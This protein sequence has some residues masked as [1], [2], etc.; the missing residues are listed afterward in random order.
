MATAIF[1]LVLVQQCLWNQATAKDLN[2]YLQFN[3]EICT[4]FLIF[5]C[6]YFINPSFDQ[7]YLG[8][9]TIWRSKLRKHFEECEKHS[10]SLGKLLC[11]VRKVM[12]PCLP[13]CLEKGVLSRKSPDNPLSKHCYLS[14]SVRQRC[15]TMKPLGINKRSQVCKLLWNVHILHLV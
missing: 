13:I 4:G 6:V 1:N 5:K 14:Q 9:G 15:L 11:K 7:F 2:D 10:W 8:P 3:T 12:S